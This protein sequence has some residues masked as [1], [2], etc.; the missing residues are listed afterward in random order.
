MAS[1]VVE[2]G[3]TVWYLKQ[4]AAAATSD[5]TSLLTPLST[6]S[7]SNPS[8][9]TTAIVNEVEIEA[10]EG[11]LVGVHREDNPQEPFYTIRLTAGRETQTE[12]HR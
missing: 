2:K 3:T 8:P 9:S 7:S 1:D 5:Y 6:P 11:S 4:S 10:V 12:G